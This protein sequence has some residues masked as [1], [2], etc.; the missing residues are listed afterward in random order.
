MRSEINTT[1]P[2][3]IQQTANQIKDGLAALAIKTRT[4]VNPALRAGTAAAISLAA[5]AG[6]DAG[7]KTVSAEHGDGTRNRSINNAPEYTWF[8]PIGATGE[9]WSYWTTLKKT[10]IPGAGVFDDGENGVI[11]LTCEQG[12]GGVDV[13]TNTRYVQDA[14]GNDGAQP[15]VWVR[16]GAP[17]DTLVLMDIPNNSDSKPVD[18]VALDNGFGGLLVPGDRDTQY[19]LRLGCASNFESPRRV[20][21]SNISRTDAQNPRHKSVIDIG[22]AFGISQSAVPAQPRVETPTLA[23]AES[24]ELKNIRINHAPKNKWYHPM[25]NNW[26]VWSYGL[27]FREPDLGTGN[28]VVDNGVIGNVLLTGKGAMGIDLSTDVQRLGDYKGPNGARTASWFKAEKGDVI[29]LMDKDMNPVVQVAADDFG[30]AGIL[31]PE[32][33]NREFGLRV[34]KGSGN[35]QAVELTF[36]NLSTEDVKKPLHS[37]VIDAQSHLK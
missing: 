37:S 30:F 22:E 34:V 33:K 8:H 26:E 1:L 12:W 5:V 15:A 11:Y 16:N 14:L 6:V 10:G 21:F 7:V 24:E 19:G 31:I 28:D 23:S 35:N 20:E 9:V 18:Q 4:L 27:T 17:G 32:D 29:I 2:E 36:G 3:Q 25:S 13:K